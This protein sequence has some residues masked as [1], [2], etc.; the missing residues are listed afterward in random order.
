MA[1]SISARPASSAF[2]ASS[3]QLDVD[4]PRGTADQHHCS[5]YEPDYSVGPTNMTSTAMMSAHEY[6][7]DASLNKGAL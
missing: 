5:D 3:G 1:F 4:R 7:P 2:F 6:L